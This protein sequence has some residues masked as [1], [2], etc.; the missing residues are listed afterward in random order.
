[1]MSRKLP[2]WILSVALGSVFLWF[3][4]DKFVHPILWTGFLPAWMDGFFGI[5][6]ETWI[7]VIGVLEIVMGAMVLIPQ[8]HV[9]LAGAT[10]IILHLLGVLSQ[11]GLDNDVGVRDAGLMLSGV[12][13]AVILADKHLPRA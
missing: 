1:M 9:R 8:R 3:G 13:L 2:A 4:I 5:P 6:K 11:V 7:T 10:W 12:A